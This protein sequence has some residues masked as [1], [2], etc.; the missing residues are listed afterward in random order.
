MDVVFWDEYVYEEIMSTFNP[1]ILNN[2]NHVPVLPISA[3]SG[4][5]IQVV[6]DQAKC[7]WYRGDALTTTLDSMCIN[8]EKY[9]KYPLRLV[10]LKSFRVNNLQ[11]LVGQI[12]SGT[13]C[14]GEEVLIMPKKIQATV[15][16]LQ[17]KLDILDQT[18]AGND[19]TVIIDTKQEMPIDYFAGCMLSSLILP[20]SVTDEFIAKLYINSKR[21]GRTLIS[22]G[23]RC[24]CIC[25]GTCG[26]VDFV[27]LL[28][29]YTRKNELKKRK[30]RFAT[31]GAIVVAHLCA[32]KPFCL[33]K[34]D[35]NER[36]GHFTLFQDGTIVGHGKVLSVHKPI[37]H[38]EIRSFCSNWPES[39]TYLDTLLMDDLACFFI[40]YQSR[41][42]VLKMVPTEL[43]SYIARN[44]INL[45]YM[46]IYHNT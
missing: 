4:D 24:S 9:E 32:V 41:H 13:I 31:G 21:N 33:E 8:L 42:P 19:V 20:S 12:N 39:F 16:Q 11:H 34:F 35:V 1:I 28:A 17:N 25:N 40:I 15:I 18:I 38:K 37:S 6:V 22:A 10:V 36:L 27:R 2:R 45:Y 7:S 29:E 3:K 26:E 30:P 46:K 14:T 44:V 5:N 23:Y 43:M